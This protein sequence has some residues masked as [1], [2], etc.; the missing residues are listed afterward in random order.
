MNQNR[1]FCI[2]MSITFLITLP[3]NKDAVKLPTGLAAM[4]YPI[5]D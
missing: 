1:L 3:S 2:L 5:V 4:I